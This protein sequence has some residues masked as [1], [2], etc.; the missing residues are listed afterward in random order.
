VVVER[1]FNTIGLKE[2][3]PQRVAEIDRKKSGWQ[4]TCGDVLIGEAII[5]L[6][7]SSRPTSWRFNTSAFES[8]EPKESPTQISDV[9]LSRVRWF[10][11]QQANRISSTT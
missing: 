8:L 3:D 10:L 4:L 2:A 9:T 5:P 7:S 11:H 6:D 1:D